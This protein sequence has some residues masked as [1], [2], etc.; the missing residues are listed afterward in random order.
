MIPELGVDRF[1]GRTDR[2]DR[3]GSILTLV[4]AVLV[5]ALFLRR[6]RPDRELD[7]AQTWTA[8]TTGDGVAGIIVR[9]HPPARARCLGF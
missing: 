8:L 6:S 1:S 9:R 4:L 7:A 5:A 3:S 2:A